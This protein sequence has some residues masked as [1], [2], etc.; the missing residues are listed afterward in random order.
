[1]EPEGSLP[2]SQVPATFPYSEPARSCSCPTSHFLKIRLSIILQST[3]G[4]FMCSLTLRFPHQNPVYASP[5]PLRSTCPAY[6]ILFDFITRTIFGEDYRS[7]SS[8]LCSFLHSPVTSS[9]LGPNIL[10]NT[11]FSNP[12][13]TFLPQYERPSFTSIQK[14]RQ[15]CSSLYPLI[16]N[17]LIANWTTKRFCTE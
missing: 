2:H 14:N 17:F 10:L 11:L 13:P 12:Q 9:L 8:S 16:F 3:P 5:L 4:S 7:F 1:M 6:L 15:N